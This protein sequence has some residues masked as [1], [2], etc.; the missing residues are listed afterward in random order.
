MREEKPEVP[1]GAPLARTLAKLK[2]GRAITVVTMGDSLTAKR[3]W[4]NREVCWVDLLRDG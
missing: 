1:P 4:A 3:H 2:S